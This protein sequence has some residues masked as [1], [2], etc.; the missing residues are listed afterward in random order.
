MVQCCTHPGCNIPS[1]YGLEGQRR[2]RCVFHKTDDMVVNKCC[3][4]PGCYTIPTFRFFGGKPDRCDTHLREAAKSQTRLDI[5]M[6]ARLTQLVGAPRKTTA[7]AAHAAV[8]S[9]SKPDTPSQSCAAQSTST[10]CTVAEGEVDIRT[11]LDNVPYK[12]GSG[13]YARC[14]EEP[15]C[16]NAPLFAVEGAGGKATFRHR[17]RCKMH[18]TDGMVNV[19]K[20]CVSEGCLSA[21]VRNND[22]CKR[23]YDRKKSAPS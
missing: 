5:R 17:S 14:C 20:I 7:Q 6:T 15:G 21:V 8:Q 10:P 16:R 11:K 13:R 3:E 22:Y 1:T 19:S 12:I 2:T 23:C 9:P 18:R 4:V